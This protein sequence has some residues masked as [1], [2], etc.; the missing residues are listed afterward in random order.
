MRPLPASGPH[1]NEA[2]ADRQRILERSEDA[3]RHRFRGA[4]VPGGLE[5]DDCEFIAAEPGDVVVGSYTRRQPL[6]HP[7]E[8]GVACA[9]TDDRLASP[10]RPS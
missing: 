9:M 6:G 2:V 8:Q 4:A 1:R 5:G 7:D 3:L 10:V